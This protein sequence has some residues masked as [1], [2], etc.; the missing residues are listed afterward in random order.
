MRKAFLAIA[1]LAAG[2]A[3]AKP[4]DVPVTYYRLQN[5]LKVVISEA[6]AAPAVTVAVYYG[7]GFRVEPKGRTGFAHLFEHM[8][9]QGSANVKKEEHARVVETNGG[10]FN[11]STNLDY[12]NYYETL[13]SDRVERA[14]FLEADRMR[15]LDVSP[16]NLKNQQNV[17]S[18]EV[19]NNVLNQPYALFEWLDLWQNANE[20]W[21]NAHN[22]YGDLSDLEAAKVDDVRDFFRTYYAPNNAVLAIVGDVDTASVRQLVDKYFADIPLQSVPDHADVSEPKQ[23]KEKRVKQTDKL[24][25]L[26]ALAIGY[27][28]PAMDSN[29]Y[30]PI[31][32]LS[33]IL[34]GGDGSRLHERIVKEKAL[35]LDWSGGV[36]AT[37]GN[38]FDYDGP[39]L[40]TMRTTYKPGHTGDEVVKEVDA[41]LADV[42][43]HGVTKKELANAKTQLRSNLYDQLESSSGR[44]H[45]LATLALFRDDPASVN[46]LLA[47]FETVTQEQVQEAA[48]RW[49]VPENRTVIDRVPATAEVTK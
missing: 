3:N 7:V 24:A 8:M 1:L 18:E 32:L 4:L 6:H 17:V 15:S 12:T 49:M 36:N 37:L 9:F 14:L 22:F 5:G 43:A 29:D 34:Q 11:G 33:I 39:M 20:N 30:A 21:A 13:P 46:K 38:E 23:A 48:K 10:N 42:I 2:V 41:V 35:A 44:A 27:H 31:A 45:I 16:E 19:R 26:P 25:N 47:P 28:V 40:M